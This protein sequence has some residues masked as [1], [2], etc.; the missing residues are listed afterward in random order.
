M[1]VSEQGSGSTRG[2]GRLERRLLEVAFAE[3]N[4]QLRVHGTA[5]MVRLAVR[6]TGGYSTRSTAVDLPCGGT[7]TFGLGIEVFP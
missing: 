5:E 4:L 6:S 2:S 7:S 3:Q 1:T